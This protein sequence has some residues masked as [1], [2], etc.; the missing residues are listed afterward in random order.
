MN[1]DFLPGTVTG[2]S[3]D[4]EVLSAAHGKLCQVVA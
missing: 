4:S 3:T 1:K 2:K